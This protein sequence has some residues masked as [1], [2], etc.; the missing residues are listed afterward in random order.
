VALAP[1]TRIG[2][3]EVAE[4]I[5]EGGMGEVYRAWDV[6][7]AR[8]V[9]IK[10]LPEPLAQDNERL[11]RFEREAKTL[12]ALNHPNIAIIHGLERTDGIGTAGQASARALV[13]E[14]VEGPTLA[15]RIRQGPIPLD[16]A[17]PIARAIA[18]ALEAAHEQGIVHR[19]LKPANVKIRAD[20]AVK[21]LDFGLAKTMEP[22]AALSPGRSLSP[23]VTSPAMTQAG[24]ILGTA[25]YMSPEQA[26]GRPADKRSDLWAFGC[27]LYE[28]LTA[29]RAFE[30]DDVSET[31]ASILRSDP[32]WRALPAETPATIRRL[33]RRCL[34]KDRKRR[35]ADAADARL[36]LEDARSIEPQAMPASGS[37]HRARPW[38]IGVASALIGAV[39]GVAG[40]WIIT[41]PDP[42][43]VTRMAI[44]R[45]PAALGTG[46]TV[47]IT[48]DG[49]RV[50]YR[51]FGAL[52]M[53]ALDALEPVVLA[54]GPPGSPF[55]SPDGEWVGFFDGGALKKIAI[56][57]GPAL[58]IA[59]G[60]GQPGLATWGPDNTIV[61]STNAPSGLRRVHADGG[62]VA[63][64]TTPDTAAAQFDHDFPHFLPDGKAVIFTIR[65]LA[66]G[67]AATQIA[68]LDLETGTQKVLLHGGSHARYLPTGHL[69]YGADGA[70]RAVRFDP[71]RRSVLGTSVPVLTQVAITGV[72]HA[73]VASNGTLVYLEGTGVT[74]QQR[75]LVW[76]D[77]DGKEQPLPA[78]P[79]AYQYPRLSPDGT[80]A[81]VYGGDQDLYIYDLARA[82]LT[83]VTHD[84]SS[85]NLGLWMPDNK[86]IVFNSN[87]GG[88]Q[89]LYL[90]AADGTGQATRLTQSSGQ[91][92]PT[93]VTPD[94]SAVVFYETTANQQRNIGLLKLLPSPQTIWLLET[95]FDERGGVVSPDGRWLAY[96]ANN[97]ADRYEVFVRPFPNVNDGVWQISTSGGA[98]PLWAPNGRELFYASLDG[99]LMSTP[100]Q[101]KGSVWSHGTPTKVLDGNYVLAPGLSTRQY[102]VTADGKRF[103]LVKAPSADVDRAPSIIVVQNW[104]EELKRLVPVN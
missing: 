10:V 15:D 95:P 65:P 81:L 29:R 71:R 43:R 68:L 75:T 49:T 38:L 92:F 7:L 18:E 8:Q 41:R 72:V 63:V 62:E 45:S 25:A 36:E 77:R 3:Y 90:Q 27:L 94:G 87:R 59:R 78:V 39:A 101:A 54:K 57:G 31:L 51:D 60:I 9:A 22:A 30:G 97:N 12:A 70:L 73:D 104:L 46:T 20:G 48:P 2:P 16:E 80:R 86:R 6:N 89:N 28:M 55:V 102:D 61:F 33:L 37:R 19:D 84:P 64:L 42:A 34:E 17:L 83:R 91:Q 21:V 76:T 56:T 96:D 13:M 69:V 74:D 40:L 32:D 99:P 4:L 50:V 82:T 35:L 14:L 67:L 26:K 47:A 24:M 1:G 5:G 23:T 58:T 88:A 11:A 98:Q 85:E 93:A 79:R 44:P 52:L 53:R 100:V 66:G 103:I